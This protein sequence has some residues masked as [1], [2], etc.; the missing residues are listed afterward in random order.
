M[1]SLANTSDLYLGLE[2]GYMCAY[3]TTRTS[4][5]CPKGGVHMVSNAL[6]FTAVTVTVTEGNYL[7]WGLVVGV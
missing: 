1:K 3:R 4:S 5:I 2:V 6:Y 7:C